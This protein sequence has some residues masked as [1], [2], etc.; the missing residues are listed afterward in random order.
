MPSWWPFRRRSADALPSLP[1]AQ[2]EPR[3]RADAWR[4]TREDGW[5]DPYTGMGSDDRDPRGAS[6]YTADLVTALQAA[7]MV[8]GD[9]LAG[10]LVEDIVLEAFRIGFEL[11]IKERDRTRGKNGQ[12]STVDVR[13]AD[14]LKADVRAMWA[15]TGLDA[16]G[17]LAEAT[18]LERQ[19]GGA[20][21]LLGLNDMRTKPNEPAA[22]NAKLE[23]LQVIH[24]S[25]LHP[26]RYYSDPFQP[27]Q[28]QVELWRLTPVVRAG[29]GGMSSSAPIVVHESRLIVL[30][31]QRVAGADAMNTTYEYPEF[32]DSVLTR[33]K[34]AVRRFYAALDSIELTA[35]RNGEPWWKLENLSD[36]IAKD[37]GK[38]FRQRLAAK[39]LAR[40]T[41]RLHVVDSKDDFG[42][43]AAPLT[44][45]K[46][47]VETFKDELAA[48]TGMP[49]QRLFGETPAGIG[50]TGQG[51]QQVWLDW[52]AAWAMAKAVPPLTQITARWLAG[53]GG[54]PLEWEIEPRDGWQMSEKEQ[55]EIEKLEADTD[56][57]LVTA[58]IISPREARR[59]E[60]IQLRYQLEDDEVDDTADLV[61]PDDIREG[62]EAGGAGE[63]GAPGAGGAELQKTALNGAQVSSLLEVV[64][65]VA[66]GEIPRE[67]GIEIVVG[68][69]PESYD[70]AGAERLMGPKDF[71]PT[72]PDPPPLPPGM[73]PP[74]GAAGGDEQPKPG[75]KRAPAPKPPTVEPTVPARGKERDR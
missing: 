46:E 40:S 1:P 23:W 62:E 12:A 38:L 30:R 9:G 49:R 45:L 8:R 25:N 22:A 15:P 47:V 24:P 20:A 75:A 27:K 37:R 50:N 21:V 71:E 4:D 18:M 34:A 33:A 29:A 48:V 39:E 52:V 42:M 36:L 60:A 61:P 74:P 3:P 5:K 7:E 44:G 19:D 32:G 65:A 55:A 51:P 57:V 26:E 17:K 58:A 53:Q 73:G 16:L 13:P 56:A 41:L 10:K 6:I 70:R 66:A 11:N 59:R 35:R 28:G 63:G 64:R 68:A 14:Q 69:F 67:A 54:E 72:K 31:G 2:P 43:A